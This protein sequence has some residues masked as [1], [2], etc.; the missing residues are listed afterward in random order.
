MLSSL[1]APR[2][3]ADLLRRLYRLPI[4]LLA[5]SSLGVNFERIVTDT[6]GHCEQSVF[7][8]SWDG[9]PFEAALVGGIVCIQDGGHGFL[10]LELGVPVHSTVALDV[11]FWNQVA[12]LDSATTVLFR[13]PPGAVIADLMSWCNGPSM[14]PANTDNHKIYVEIP[15]SVLEHTFPRFSYSSSLFL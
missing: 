14:D 7:V 8:R 6:A 2:F 15:P 4:T 5:D 1:S 11:F 10:T 13:P 12:C 3:Y 9:R